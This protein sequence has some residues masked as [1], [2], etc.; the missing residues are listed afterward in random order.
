MTAARLSS[1]CLA[2]AFLMAALRNAQ[3]QPPSASAVGHELLSDGKYVV[4]NSQLDLEDIVTSPAHIVYPES[5]F[6]SPKFYL[7]LA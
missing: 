2:L 7:A 5:P 3:A 4:N 1:L 6:R